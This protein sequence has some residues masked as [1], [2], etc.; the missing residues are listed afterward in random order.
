[1]AIYKYVGRTK[2]GQLKKGTID[3]LNKTNAIAKLR[4][5]GISPVRSMKQKA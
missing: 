3:A 5:Q 1:M 2:T 4:E